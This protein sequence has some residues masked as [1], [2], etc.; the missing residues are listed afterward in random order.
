MPKIYEEY[1]PEKHIPN[2]AIT[3]IRPDVLK[4]RF[5]EAYSLIG[6][7][8]KTCDLLGMVRR[9]FYY[10]KRDD[11]EFAEAFEFADQMAL[12]MLEDEA[13]L[14]A[15]YGVDKPVYQGGKL[16]GYVKEYSDSLLVVLLKARAPH[17]YKERF[18][19]ELTGADGKPLSSEHKIIHVHSNVPMAEAEE[20]IDTAR[21]IEDIPHEEVP[22]P[23]PNIDELDELLR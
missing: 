5:L 6:S 16:V 1:R 15:A 21:Q 2:V 4:K 17:K 22:P 20:Y 10:W 3:H 11:K 8:T 18:A 14:R 19:G 13:V 12:G 9:T 23:N 7:I